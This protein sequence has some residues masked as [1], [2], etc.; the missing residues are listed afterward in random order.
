MQ[1][2]QE[3]IDFVVRLLNSKLNKFYFYHN[4]EHS[5]YVLDKAT[6][7]AHHQ[8]CSVIEIELVRA[9]ALWHDTGFINI[10]K[11]HEEEGC[12]L[13]NIYLPD[14]GFSADAIKIICGMIRA[15]KLPQLPKNKLEQILADA[16]LEY[17]GTNN[18]AAIA[19][20]LFKERQSLNPGFT[21]D[22]FNKMQ[23]L[24]L[25]NHRYFTN[26]CKE[27]K[28]HIKQTYLKKLVNHEVTNLG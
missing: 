5:L 12:N 28:E 13:V 25:Q 19:N 6:E 14:F 11:G 8:N 21:A 22:Q 15:T 10:Y 1:N 24:F 7:I 3:M 20:K 23:I 17:L 27:N 2:D 9:A 4:A 16:D 26:F 18:A